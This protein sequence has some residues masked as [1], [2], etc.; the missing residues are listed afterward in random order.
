MKRYDIYLES[1]YGTLSEATIKL[2]EER[3]DAGDW[4]RYED[5][6]ARAD[7]AGSAMACIA[8]LEFIVKRALKGIPVRDAD[9][10]LNFAAG[11]REEYDAL[12]DAT[13]R[14]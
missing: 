11:L 5:A 9:E 8:H 14:E 13:G 4:V 10:A 7:I 2:V 12:N 6:K 3:D 1:G